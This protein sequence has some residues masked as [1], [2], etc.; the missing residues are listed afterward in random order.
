MRDEPA[1]DPAPNADQ[2]E[3]WNSE[4]GRRWITCQQALDQRFAPLT[5]LLIARASVRPGDCAIDIG[6]GTGATTLELAAAVGAH[7]SVLAVDISEPLL[8]VARRR[9]MQSRRSNVR[10]AHADAQTHRFERGCHDLAMSRFGVMFFADPIGAF[11]NLKRALRPGGRLAFACWDR[12]EDNPWFALPLQVGIERLGPLEPRPPRA[13]GPLA[14]AEQD[15]IDE[16]LTGAGLIDVRIE[17]A[18]TLLP[19]AKSAREEAELAS[20]VGFLARLLR[21]RGADEATRRLLVE[22]LADR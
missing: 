2:A 12:L 5:D 15:Y 14:L 16:I 22:E 3:Y 19:G 18:D 6:C 8:A 20:Q 9:V 17:R 11:A 13:P 10:F 7:G 4:V 1:V 21:E